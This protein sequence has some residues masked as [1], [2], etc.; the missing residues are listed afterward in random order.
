MAK[1][2]IVYG[3]TTG[4]TQ[5]VAEKVAAA[6]GG[7]LIDVSGASASALDGYDVLV[8]GC[9]TWGSGDLQDDWN[10]F[11]DDF[12]KLSL[13]GKK[14]ALFGTGDQEGFGDTFVDALGTLYDSAVGC[15]AQMIGAWPTEGYSATDSQAVRDGKFVGLAID[16]NNQSDLTDQRIEAWV[17]ELQAQI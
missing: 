3:S 6:L 1:I 17:K 5:G 7:E 4:A 10:S 13:Q 8:L 9:S 2:A 14:V 11:I 15:G 16:E 12:E